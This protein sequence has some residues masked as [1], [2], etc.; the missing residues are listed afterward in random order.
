[1][2]TER[3]L[4]NTKLVVR[5][6]TILVSFMVPFMG[7]AVNIAVP[8]IGDQ[9]HMNAVVLGWVGTSYF[10]ASAALLVPFGRLADIYGRKKIFAAGTITFGLG[11][12]LCI[13][14]NSTFFFIGARV[15]QGIGG[16]MILSNSIAMLTS[17]YPPGERGRVLGINSASVYLGLS[18][19]PFLGGLLTDHIGWRSIFVVG[20]AS[21]FLIALLVF[22]K[23]R[24]EWKEAGGESFDYGGS[25]IFTAS[26][27]ALIYGMTSLPHVAGA[28][29]LAVG[30]VGML[31]F[32]AWENRA[33]S[34]LLRLDL[35]KNNH[36]FVFSNVATLVS[37]AATYAVTFL[38][39]LYLQYNKGLSPE[40]AGLVLLTT[41]AMQSICSP[42]AGRLSDRIEP[43]KLA[44]AGMAVTTVAMGLLIFVGQDTSLTY[45]RV[46]LAILG[47]GFG[48]FVSPN[49]N[50][51]MTSASK[52][53]YGVA[54]AALATSRQVGA[55]LSMGIA[56]LII[57]IF[58]GR[59]EITP[60][61]YDAFARG[62][63]VAF[64]IFTALC[65]VGI[66]ASLA[67]GNV[68]QE[69]TNGDKPV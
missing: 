37:Y 3:T 16:A 9:L 27:V 5:V 31:A 54:S 28:L 13:I 48:V 30:L 19:G 65:L 24:S 2:K 34:P 7:S 44:S 11:S 18:L 66:F 33:P 1:M 4:G 43:R 68:H 55:M 51:I 10:L 21:S 35:F 38:L 12:V 42:I 52:R 45:L 14:A 60:E 22:W 59:V 69:D 23:L 20:F 39:S 64:I 58:V 57:G 46:T 56:M 47:L 8:K 50:A 49:T 53:W 41:P 17:V 25:I 40:A 15:V 61:H 29:V 32:V 67:R 62:V 6:I 26:L 36:A 63:R